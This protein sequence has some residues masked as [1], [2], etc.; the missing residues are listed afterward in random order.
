MRRCLWLLFVSLTLAPSLL[1]QKRAFTIEDLYRVKSVSDIH[2]SPD[3]GRILYTVGTPDLAR[4]RRTSQIWMMNM[5]GTNAHQILQNEKG[6]NSPQ[7]SPD[8]K[9][10]SFIA[11]SNLYV[12]S[13]G[14]GAARK[15]TELST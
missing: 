12:A 4:A 7:F 11:N 5:D 2:V 3:G 15:L 14:G 8:G 13:T 1:A 6:A 10:M 9:W